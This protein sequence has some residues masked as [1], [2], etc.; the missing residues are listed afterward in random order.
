MALDASNPVVRETLSKIDDLVFEELEAVKRAQAFEANAQNQR[1]VAKITVETRREY[2]E[3]AVALGV[4]GETMAQIRGDVEDRWN[5][6]NNRESVGNPRK[7]LR[8]TP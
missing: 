1:D 4:S 6:V 5:R 2:E 7:R 3:A 8:A